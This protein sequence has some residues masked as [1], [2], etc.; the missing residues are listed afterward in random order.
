M[1]KWF[2]DVSAQARSQGYLFV[3]R[4]GSGHFQFRHVQYGCTVVTAATP[5]DWRSLKN[6]HRDCRRAVTVAHGR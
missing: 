1:T 3:R 5:S 6:F 4:T 2:R